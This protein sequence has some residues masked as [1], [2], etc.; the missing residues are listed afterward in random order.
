[1]KNWPDYREE[2]SDGLV[3]GWKGDEYRDAC[4]CCALFTEGLECESS[5]YARGQVALIADLYPHLEMPIDERMD[6][7]YADVKR[8]W[9]ETN[10]EHEPDDPN[11][12]GDP[13]Y[14]K[15]NN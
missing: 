10:G 3:T 8:V 15:V 5:E 6:E 2:T 13:D 1:M 14:D 11:Y 9:R 7:V 4:L 12:Q